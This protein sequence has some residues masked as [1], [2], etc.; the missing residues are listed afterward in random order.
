MK[1]LRAT[2]TPFFRLSAWRPNSDKTSMPTSNYNPI[3][4][5][6]QENQLEG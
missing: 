6:P 5:W 4:A 3:E 2:S 1:E